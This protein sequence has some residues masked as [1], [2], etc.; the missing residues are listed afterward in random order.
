MQQLAQVDAA[1]SCASESRQV[2]QVQQ[3][4]GCVES[5]AGSALW[6]LCSGFL[7]CTRPTQTCSACCSGSQTGR[8]ASSPFS[9]SSYLCV[10]ACVFVRTLACEIIMA[11][12]SGGEAVDHM[13]K[14]LLIGAESVGKSSIL[15]RFTDNTF[16]ESQPAT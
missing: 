2:A 11:R 3:R 9:D 8:R 12:A 7:P 4:H 16:D 1:T 10:C 14:L 15:L 5:F 13:V 6:V